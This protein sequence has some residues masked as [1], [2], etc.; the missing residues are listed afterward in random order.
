MNAESRQ[1]VPAKLRAGLFL[2]QL[3]LKADLP[4]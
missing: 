4:L 3:G 2:L 1:I